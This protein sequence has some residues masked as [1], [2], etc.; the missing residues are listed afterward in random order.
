MERPEDEL[1]FYLYKLKDIG[2]KQFQIIVWEL[3]KHIEDADMSEVL[4][5]YAV[6]IG[7]GKEVLP[8]LATRSGQC[9]TRRCP[10]GSHES[11]AE[12]WPCHSTRL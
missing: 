10:T 11:S 2:T 7:M 3:P 1:Q 4:N 5:S 9:A 8:Y 6:H 12:A